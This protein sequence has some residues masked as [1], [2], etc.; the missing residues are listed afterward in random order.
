MANFPTSPAR[1]MGSTLGVEVEPAPISAIHGAGGNQP[2]KQL[3]KKFKNGGNMRSCLSVSGRLPDIN[4]GVICEAG[5]QIP[6]LQRI[7]VSGE[8]RI[9]PCFPR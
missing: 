7:F 4:Q 5:L 3:K 2:S 6:E 1:G 9:Y 8:G